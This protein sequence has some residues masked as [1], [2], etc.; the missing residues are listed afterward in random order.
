MYPVEIKKMKRI[1]SLIKKQVD[2]SQFTNE[3]IKTRK[4]YNTYVTLIYV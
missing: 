2:T 3:S 1:N 4:V